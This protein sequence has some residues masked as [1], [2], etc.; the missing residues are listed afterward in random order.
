MDGNLVGLIIAGVLNIGLILAE[1]AKNKDGQS[2]FK[3]LIII[4]G[5]A[6]VWFGFQWK[7]WLGAVGSYLVI[8]IAL[9]VIKGLRRR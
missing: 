2:A 3:P 9:G 8:L 6:V 1:S 5:L 4:S 7:S